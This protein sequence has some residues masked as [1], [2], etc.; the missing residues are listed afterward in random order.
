MGN[1]GC[2]FAFLQEKCPRLNKEKLKTG[3]FDG[4]QIKELM[5]DLMFDEALELSPWQ[6]LK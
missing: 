3:I 2:G 1:E 5:K 6:S 4:P